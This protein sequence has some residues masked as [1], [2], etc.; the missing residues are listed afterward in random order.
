MPRVTIR[1]N[2]GSFPEVTRVFAYCPE[3]GRAFV[4]LRYDPDGRS[5][6]ICQLEF[7]EMEAL[8]HKR[9]FADL[10]AALRQRAE[11]IHKAP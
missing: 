9:N 7:S 11:Y 4:L 3:D 2:F 1:Q 5:T 6:G 8:D 10:D